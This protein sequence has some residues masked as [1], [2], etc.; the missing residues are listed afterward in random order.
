MQIVRSLG[1]LR[2]LCR[3][4][5]FNSDY[6]LITQSMIDA[7]ADCTLDR[8]WIH[9]DPVRAAAE[10]P[11]GTTVAHGFLTLSL[12][13][14][15]FVECL[16]FEKRRMGVNFGFDR[17]RFTAPVRVGARVRGSFQLEEV[18]DLEPAGAQCLWDARVEIERVDK[19]AL[20]AKWLTR[21][22]D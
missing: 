20:V 12:L 1:E 17:V 14:H 9:V 11:F 7:F 8:Q 21:L 2:Q 13:S 5:R 10:S 19:P 18:Q 4:P 6:L 16:V 22:Y 15:F 3:A